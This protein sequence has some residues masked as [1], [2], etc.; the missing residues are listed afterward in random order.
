VGG[1]D[2]DD[3]DVDQLA[4]L[5]EEAEHTFMDARDRIAQ[6]RS[7]GDAG[8]TGRA[9]IRGRYVALILI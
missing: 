2:T 8:L 4:A 7:T 5:Y 1:W 3:D 6:A 9:G